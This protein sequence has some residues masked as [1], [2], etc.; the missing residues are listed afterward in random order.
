[1]Q[2]STVIGRVAAVAAVVVALI[3]V[4]VIVLSSGS[5]YQVRAVFANASQIVSGDLVEVSGSSIGTVSNIALTPTGQAELTFNITNQSYDPLRWGTQA[6]IRELSLSGI[7]SRYVDLHP[8]SVAN[9]AIPRN[10]V[11]S[12]TDTT[13][14]VDLDEIFNTLNG[15]TLKGL[16]DVFRGSGAQWKG[17]GKAAQA[18]FAYLNPA[19]VAS[20]T[21]FRELNRNTGNFTNFIVKTSHLVSDVSTRS[22]DLSGLV[23]HLATTTQALA[24]QRTDLASSLQQLPGFMRLANTTFVNLRTALDDLKPLVDDS[25]PVAPKLEK[26]LVQLRPLA[27]NAV[28]T[29]NDLSDIIRRPGAD[30]DLIELTKLGVPLAAATVKDVTANGKVR[31]G[32]FPESTR[33][34][35]DSTPELATA[36]PYA[37]DLTGWFEGYTHPGVLDANG[38][39]SRIAPVVGIGSIENGA[40]NLLPS[41]TTPACRALNAFGSSIPGLSAVTGVTQSVCS[42]AGATGTGAGNSSQGLLVTGQGDR[43]P[44][45]MERGALYYPESGFPCDP[46]EVPTGK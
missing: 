31:S 10:G 12:T 39:T 41:F 15:P 27:R 36:R 3:A 25:K 2:N 9:A 1:V 30:N 8:G 28:P 22:S 23:S 37:V 40:L 4:A 13:S 18:A 26:L 20:S 42:V 33:A 32:A 21:L 5:S 35:N 16:Q 19:V 34:L 43:C 7:A 44:G 14:E 11:I 24:S 46:S 17:S 38:G 45:S 29:L 6:T